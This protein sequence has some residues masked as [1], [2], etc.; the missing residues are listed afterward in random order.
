MTRNF[1]YDFLKLEFEPIYEDIKALEEKRVFEEI[2]NE[3]EILID[4]II[5]FIYKKN[6]V[7]YD[8]KVGYLKRLQILKEINI[9]PNDIFNKIILFNEVM[10]DKSKFQGTEE[11]KEKVIDKIFSE[12]YEIMVWLVINCGEENYSLIIESLSEK[13]LRVFTKYLPSYKTNTISEKDI[14][15]SSDNKLSDDEENNEKISRLVEAGE[16]FY[17][18]RG[19]SKSS[20]KAYECFIEAA[21]FKNEYAESYLGLFYEKGIAVNRNYEIAFQWYYK[22]A[23]KGNAFAQYALGMLY[24]DGNGI[25]R[26]YYKAFIWLQKSAEN[27]YIA[28][29]YQLGRCYYGGFGCEESKEKAFKWYQKAAESNFAA[30]QY[31]LSLM[32]KNGEGCTTNMISAYYWIEKS[33]ENGY[34]DAYYVIGK[35]YLDGIYVDVDYEKAFYYLSKG[36]EAL[37]TSCIEA[38]GDMYLRGLKGKKDVFKALEYYHIAIDYGENGLFFKVG[39]IY[40]EEGVIEEAIKAYE[41]GHEIG[42]LKCTQ[43]LGIMYYNGEG[44][45]R[46]LDKAIGYMQIAVG[47]KEPH[48]MYVLAVAYLRTN[49]FGEKTTETAKSL[50]KNAF[51]LKS[52]YAAESLASL[53]INELGEGKQIDTAE[54]IKYIKFGAE[55]GLE[56]AIFQYGYIYEKGIGVNTDLETAYYY[57]NIAAEKNSINAMLKIA[58]WYKRGIYFKYN[59]DLAITW[60]EKA[61]EKGDLDATESLIEIYEKGF[62]DRQ[63]DLKAIFYVFKLCDL[64]M[65]KGKEKLAYYCFKG[66]GIEEN[67]EKGNELIKEV[68]ELDKGSADYL[69][70]KLAREDFIEMSQDEIIRLYEDGIEHGNLKCYGEL[71]VYLYNNDL[72]DKEKYVD[73]FSLAMEGKDLGSYKCSYIYLMQ[74]LKETQKSSIV[75]VEELII[76][77]K[78]KLLINKGIYEGIND[79]ITWYKT[80][81]VEDKQGY[82]ELMQQAYYYKI[83]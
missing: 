78:I 61:A 73:K 79:L 35:S 83:L 64:D 62:G 58:D 54:L 9:L 48:A 1:R 44:V 69:R 66:I 22:A 36:Y 15:K 57:Y 41:Q 16:N 47:K 38:L 7:L 74:K 71:A 49:K 3:I 82:Y 45:E 76:V 23:I 8:D 42:N 63:S 40:E 24:F 4:D 20:K 43:R 17:L 26:D 12:L 75:T 46:D 34:E 27:D 56:N 28:S 55:N 5:Y 29:F 68:E 53:M 37:D 30:A 80:R 77:K 59:I 67:E 2:K 13:E 6:K 33:A 19:V 52:P 14:N 10:N 60:Y 11:E 51:E 25:V 31:A 70:A 18:G 72:Y 65:I 39:K 81:K 32:Y 21:K 50:L